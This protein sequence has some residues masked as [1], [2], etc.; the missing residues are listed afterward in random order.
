MDNKSHQIQQPSSCNKQQRRRQK[1]IY[2]FEEARKIA[3]SHGFTSEAEFKDYEC[4]GSYQLPKNVDEIYTQT[5]EWRGWD[6]FL[7]VPLSY[8]EGRSIV[9]TLGI[10]NK[11][12]FLHMKECK[13][14]SES[15]SETE[16]KN[17]NGNGNKRQSKLTI[18]KASASAT[19]TVT[20]TST[21]VVVDHDLIYRLPYRPDLYYKKE[22][23]SWEDWL[24]I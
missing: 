11:E 15:K 7:G 16:N 13:S 23:I 14:K 6:D 19:S 20:S 22:W 21:A 17:G 8:K 5:N 24:G 10:V 9:R 12:A 2:S 4:A 1:R 18:V 3:R